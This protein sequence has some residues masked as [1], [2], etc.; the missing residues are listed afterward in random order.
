MNRNFTTRQDYKEALLSML[1]PLK[2]YYSPGRALVQVGYTG[3]PYGEKTA[4]L[5]GFSRILWGLV[6]LWMAGEKSCLDEFIPEGIRSGTD[7]GHPEYWGE[8]H[9]CHQAYVEMA[10]LGYALL[11][12]P[13][14][15]WEPLS[16]EERARF[17]DWL[18]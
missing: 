11:A 7:P 16:R 12:A 2:K 4:G 10:A 3:A 1:E 8:Y 17:A 5:E 9:G 18:R 13:A 15:V 6:P 14:H